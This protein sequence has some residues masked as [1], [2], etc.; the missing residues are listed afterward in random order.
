MGAQ[1]CDDG[2]GEGGPSHPGIS[3]SISTAGE[4]FAEVARPD[5]QCRHF[6][7][8][9]AGLDL[10]AC[11]ASC[12]RSVRRLAALSSNDQQRADGRRL[13]AASTTGAS[14]PALERRPARSA[15]VHQN[16][17][18]LSGVLVTPHGSAHQLG[19]SFDDGEPEPRSTEGSRRR[20][21]DLAEG[22]KS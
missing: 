6:A 13:S 2:F 8:I 20:S 16:V 9:G 3:S 11:V 19:E 7:R 15:P 21:V 12:E 22:L 14:S 10:E 17:E 1:L 4:R 18:P 5:E